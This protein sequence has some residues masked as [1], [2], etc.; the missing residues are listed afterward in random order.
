LQDV[1]YY[2]VV[3]TIGLL[4]DVTLALFDRCHCSQVLC[5]MLMAWHRFALRE[6]SF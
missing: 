3:W 4:A 2:A 1:E 6:S 5:A